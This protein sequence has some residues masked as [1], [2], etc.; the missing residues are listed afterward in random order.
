MSWHGDRVSQPGASSNELEERVEREIL[1]SDIS[2]DI[3]KLDVPAEDTEVMK[4]EEGDLTHKTITCDTLN[5]TPE[6][7]HL[8]WDTWH[9]TCDGWH[10]TCDI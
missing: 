8:T 4:E 6:T 10:M 9:V 2:D 1:D 3:P 5:G 7:G